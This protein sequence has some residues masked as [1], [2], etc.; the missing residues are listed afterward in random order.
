M[1]R[2]WSVDKEGRGHLKQKELKRKQKQETAT[3][4][5]QRKFVREGVTPQE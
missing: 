5:K 4:N 1:E 3:G 2:R